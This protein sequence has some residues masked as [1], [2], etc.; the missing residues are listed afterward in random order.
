[1]E[2]EWNPIT[3]EM[4]AWH[5][6]KSNKHS[7]FPLTDCDVY[8]TVEFGYGK[9]DV[10]PARLKA[11]CWTSD[12]TQY[13]WYDTRNN[14]RITSIIDNRVKAWMYNRFPRPYEE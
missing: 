9:R 8:I 3:E 2:C 10:I 4:L 1:M 14:I 7:G 13:G 6:G 12:G 5:D 11:E